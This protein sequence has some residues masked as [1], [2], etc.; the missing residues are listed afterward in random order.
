MT[1]T[2]KGTLGV[3]GLIVLVL[4]IV[5]VV[6]STLVVYHLGEFASD[7]LYSHGIGKFKCVEP[8]YMRCIDDDF[9]PFGPWLTIFLAILTPI[10]VSSI[11]VGLVLLVYQFWKV[12]LIPL[13]SSTLKLLRFM[14]FRLVGKKKE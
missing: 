1:Q 2:K 9:I 4:G 11:S 7:W 13:G 6:S 12:A 3:L 10:V 5:T 14:G 8:D